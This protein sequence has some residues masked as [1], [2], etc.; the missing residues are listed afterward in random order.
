MARA[1]DVDFIPPEIHDLIIDHFALKPATKFWESD[2][3]VDIENRA[4]LRACSLVSRSYCARAYQRLFSSIILAVDTCKP[5]ITRDALTIRRCADIL[6]DSLQFPDIGMVYHIRSFSLRIRGANPEQM[7]TL[8][9]EGKV[10]LIVDALQ[11]PN[12]GINSMTMDVGLSTHNEVEY[13]KL[14]K[15]FLRAFDGLCHS[16]KMRHMHLQGFCSIPRILFYGTHI[17]HIEMYRTRLT[18]GD[19]MSENAQVTLM[20]SIAV[21]ESFPLV[22]LLHSDGDYVGTASRYQ[23]AFKELKKLL[24]RLCYADR[25]PSAIDIAICASNTL[26]SLHIHLSGLDSIHFIPPHSSTPK[27]VFHH[28]HKLSTLRISKD[29]GRLLEELCVIHPFRRLLES[30]TLPRSL[31]TL[32][33]ETGS[34]R[35]WYSSDPT[36]EYRPHGEWLA[37]DS[38]LVQPK[39]SAVPQLIIAIEYTV[40]LQPVEI[41]PRTRELV[42]SVLPQLRKSREIL[43]HAE[44]FHDPDAAYVDHKIVLRC[45]GQ[46]KPEDLV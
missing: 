29:V 36:P 4:T 22:N 14:D 5:H 20:E 43:P 23:V 34:A 18:R 9:Q 31:K 13:A 25:I 39:F 38:V 1:T 6:R 26:Q 24:F 21:D 32:I 30:C 12:H 8:F 2:T 46:V 27:Y 7:R 40:R 3:N 37:L 41:F 16:P 11:G 10:G 35:G 17:K 33:L 44:W 15:E 45:G 42:L 28:L 19:E